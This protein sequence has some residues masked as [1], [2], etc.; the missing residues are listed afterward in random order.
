MILRE[1]LTKETDN[2]ISIH[3]SKLNIPIQKYLISIK[4]NKITLNSSNQAQNN[5]FN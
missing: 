5:Q 4:L 2:L 1:H 3:E